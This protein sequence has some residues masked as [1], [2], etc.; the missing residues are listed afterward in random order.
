MIRH[1]VILTCY[2]GEKYIFE[3]IDSVLKQI[4]SDDE[5]IIVDDGSTDNSRA[6]ISNI[7]DDRIRMVERQVN[8]GIA[9]A[10]NDAIS[11]VRGKYVSFIDHDD[12]WGAGRVFDFENTV[13]QF[14]EADVVHGFVAHFYSEPG[15]GNRFRLPETQLSVLPGTVTMSHDLV[16]K[17]GLFDVTLTCGEFVDFMA[18]A[19]GQCVCWKSS[20]KVYLH[21]RIH[22][23]NYTL[24]HA[25]DASGYLAVVRSH[26]LRNRKISPN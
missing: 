20:D 26:L 1:S 22:G 6:I 14:P 25:K 4:S 16:R 9:R 7:K 18:R 12:Y 23:E 13:K 5:L 24:T 3:A 11:L 10:R 21:R 15:L 17:V 8:G 2:N 19:R